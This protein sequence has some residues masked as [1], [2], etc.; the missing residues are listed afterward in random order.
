MLLLL[1]GRPPVHAVR[2]NYDLVL[3][4]PRLG[5]APNLCSVYNV[6]S[7]LDPAP[8]LSTVYCIFCLPSP[9]VSLRPLLPTTFGL[10]YT[11]I[12]HHIIPLSFRSW[13]ACLPGQTFPPPGL[14]RPSLCLL[15]FCPRPAPQC[16]SKPLKPCAAT[17]AY[18]PKYIE[19]LS[20]F[21]LV[22]LFEKIHF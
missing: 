5:T 13:I 3:F 20:Y 11:A 22:P 2:P 14:H 16:P 19:F 15:N 21:K 12:L 6:M 4:Q 8:P 1:F 10:S 18:K 9:S 7:K 17:V